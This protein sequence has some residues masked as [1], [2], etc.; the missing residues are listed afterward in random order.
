[1]APGPN[2]GA[3]DK[4]LGRAGAGQRQQA[5]MTDDAGRTGLEGAD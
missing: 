4:G 1:M 2:G 3:Q 5:R